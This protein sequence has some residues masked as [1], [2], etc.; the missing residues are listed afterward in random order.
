VE[1]SFAAYPEQKVPYEFYGML[2]Q[3]AKGYPFYVALTGDKVVGYGLLRPHA[4]FGTFRRAAELTCF[5]APEHT[6]NGIGT[7]I[8]DHLAADAR[9]MGIDTILAGVSSANEGSIAFHKKYG[10]AECGRF[11]CAGKKFG[12]DFDEVW[13][14]LFLKPA[15]TSS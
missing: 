3:L 10:F 4:P 2:M 14:Q 5:I 9:G 15:G 1:N 11:R 13:L 7:L 8:L 6:G 12:K